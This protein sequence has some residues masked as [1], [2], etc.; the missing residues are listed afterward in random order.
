M[1]TVGLYDFSPVPDVDRARAG[2]RPAGLDRAT[3]TPQPRSILRVLTLNSSLLLICGVVPV[4][5]RA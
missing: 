5:S 1:Q 3:P 4:P 2:G